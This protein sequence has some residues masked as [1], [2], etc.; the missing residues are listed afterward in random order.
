MQASQSS[1]TRKK[2]ILLSVVAVC[3]ATVLK[4]FTGENKKK[5]EGDT[6]KMLTQDG[7]L[8]EINTKLITQCGGKITNEELQKWVKTKANS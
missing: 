5:D 4:F 8:V 6:V 3:S 7:K 1:P 2:F